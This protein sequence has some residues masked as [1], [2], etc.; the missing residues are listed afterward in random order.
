MSITKLFRVVIRQR[1]TWTP[2]TDLSVPDLTKPTE[3][4]GNS[5]ERDVTDFVKSYKLPKS[6]DTLSSE[7]TVTFVSPGGILNPENY[8]SIYNLDP[9]DNETFTPLLSEGNE[10]QIYRIESVADLAIPANWHSRFRGTIRSIQ[11][12]VDSGH[13]TLELVAGDILS[14]ASKATVTGNFSMPI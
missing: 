2:G 7:A 13:D 12:G 1:A 6:R 14:R 4:E 8:T 10:I 3:I 5:I 11:T 9:R